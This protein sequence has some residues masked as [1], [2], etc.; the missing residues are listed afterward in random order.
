MSPKVE[1]FEGYFREEA[2]LFHVKPGKDSD[3]KHEVG[4]DYATNSKR[5]VVSNGTF[6]RVSMGG[7]LQ[8]RMVWKKASR[9]KTAQLI[10]VGWEAVDWTNP[11]VKTFALSDELWAYLEPIK[12][13]AAHYRHCDKCGVKLREFEGGLLVIPRSGIEIQPPEDIA[14]I[15]RELGGQVSETGMKKSYFICAK[16]CPDGWAWCYRC[17]TYHPEVRAQKAI[18][19][20][21]AWLG[22]VDANPLPSGSY[23]IDGKEWLHPGDSIPIIMGHISDALVCWPKSE[24]AASA[25]SLNIR[26][27]EAIKTWSESL[28]KE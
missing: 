28:Q 20:L 24:Q 13:G 9:H 1:F 21:S 22:K 8:V 19:H 2:R 12:D 7:I 3:W 6:M 27:L 5:Q 17:L 23:Q 4:A 25:L 14:S 16:C 18:K 11:S 26:K 15:A 10:H